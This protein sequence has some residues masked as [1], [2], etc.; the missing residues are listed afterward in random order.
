LAPGQNGVEREKEMVRKRGED[1]ANINY[2]TQ[3]GKHFWSKH[4]KTKTRRLENFGKRL[5]KENIFL[6]SISIQEKRKC[7]GRT[8]FKVNG[9][10]ILE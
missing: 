8:H 3:L 2:K 4:K 7:V 5:Q 1:M 9:F 10:V 6:F